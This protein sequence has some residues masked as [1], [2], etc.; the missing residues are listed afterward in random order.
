MHAGKNEGGRIDFS[1]FFFA[2]TFGAGYAVPTIAP[3]AGK[4]KFIEPYGEPA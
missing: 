2:R 4:I 1:R 3:N